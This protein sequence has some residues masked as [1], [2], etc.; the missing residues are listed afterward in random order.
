MRKLCKRCNKWVDKNYK[1]I[2]VV[3]ML[4]ALLLSVI[5][6]MR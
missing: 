2:K 1:L 5:A 4:L 3:L 6:M